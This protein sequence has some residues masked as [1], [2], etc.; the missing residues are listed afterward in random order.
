[1]PRS[2]SSRGQE[3]PTP[4]PDEYSEFEKLTK[5]SLS[6]PKKDIDKANGKKPR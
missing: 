3:S 6:V 5:R 1:M 4:E 2:P